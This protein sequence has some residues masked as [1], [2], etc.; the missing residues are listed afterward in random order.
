MPVHDWTRVSA[1]TFHDFHVAWIGEL[2]KALNRGILP[3]GFY[4]LAEQIAG[5][6]GPDV[7]T[8]KTGEPNPTGKE[9]GPVPPGA[10]AVKE[11]P[12]RV[13]TSAVADEIEMYALKRRTLTIRYSGDDRIV[14]FVEVLSPGNKDRS[15]SLDRLIDKAFSALTAGVH[16]LLV[17]L[18]PPGRHDPQGI[19]GALWSEFDA[20]PYRLPPDRPLTLAAYSAGSLP[21]AYVEPV[22][23]GSRLPD[24]PLFIDDEWYVNVPLEATYNEA[25]SG[26]P[27]KWMRVLEGAT[28]S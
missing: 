22:S 13:H 2:R 23:V 17:D 5:D 10:T 21:R 14:A 28:R 1:G 26:V 18:H 3:E 20:K 27:G 7:L 16:L 12:P 6:I 11:S 15:R 19:H 25:Y 4:A 9:G 24:M 8:L